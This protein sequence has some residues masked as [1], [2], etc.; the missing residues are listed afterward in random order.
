MVISFRL[1]NGLTL[2]IC[3]ENDQDP[4]I[5]NFFFFFTRE[6]GF[7]F[8][9]HSYLKL[10][11]LT[12]QHSKQSKGPFCLEESELGEGEEILRA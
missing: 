1:I 2:R 9:W 6:L 12:L 7:Y 3:N 8:S 11:D 10:A 4:E 5:L